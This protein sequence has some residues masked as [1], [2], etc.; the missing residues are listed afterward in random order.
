MPTPTYKPDIVEELAKITKRLT[1]L[2][3]GF[4]IVDFSAG[5]ASLLNFSINQLPQDIVNSVITPPDWVTPLSRCIILATVNITVKNNSAGADF[6]YCRTR[7]DGTG[8]GSSF[9]GTVPVGEW[10]HGSTSAERR[11]TGLTGADIAIA[12]QAY[13]NNN[14]WTADGA[15]IANIDAIGIFLRT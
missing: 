8:G 14:V 1:A 5:S 4:A 12:G 3:R 2:E 6:L 10:A 7:I 11:M 9:T 15:N 13:S